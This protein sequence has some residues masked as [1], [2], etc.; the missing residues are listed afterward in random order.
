[1]YSDDPRLAERNLFKLHAIIY[2]AKRNRENAI[3]AQDA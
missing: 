1:M 2:E 3:D